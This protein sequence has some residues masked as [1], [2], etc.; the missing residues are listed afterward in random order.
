MIFKARYPLQEW[1][2]LAFFMCLS[3]AMA[4]DFVESFIGQVYWWFDVLRWFLWFLCPVL[5]VLVVVHMA[6]AEA[7]QLSESYR[8]LVLIPIACFVTFFMT[9]FSNSCAGSFYECD[10]FYDW[11]LVSGVLSGAFALLEIWGRRGL[12][13]KLY[14]NKTGSER[15]WLVISLIVM[16][17][18]FLFGGLLYMRDFIDSESYKTIRA[19]AGIAFFYISSTMLFRIY[20]QAVPLTGV[21]SKDIPL[22]DKERKI[23][24]KISDLIEL[25]KIYQEPSYSRSEL[26]RELEIADYQV[27]R[28]INL[29]F[30]K[31]FSQL[32]NENRVEDAKRMLLQTDV[33]IKIIAGESGFNSIASFN[34]IFRD[35][36]GISP[37]EY[38][39]RFKNAGDDDQG[40]EQDNQE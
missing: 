26:A 23:A 24:Q 14:E 27:S 40:D 2:A 38:R 25:D 15:Y 11:I 30:N 32:L 39:K 19:L 21:S 4:F 12:L 31:S 13:D 34:R 35:I 1:I 8:I 6:R 18:T 16:D 20:P 3:L 22:S 5:S 10:V 7:K 36:E 37:G 33:A 9:V 29:Y 28:I 17:I